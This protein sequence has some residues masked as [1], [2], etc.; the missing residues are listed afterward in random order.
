LKVLKA[1][2]FLIM[3]TIILFL[4]REFYYD[5][6]FD[7]TKLNINFSSLKEKWGNPDYEF[8]PNTKKDNRVFKYN[9]SIFGKYIFIADEKDSLIVRKAF[10][11]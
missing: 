6:K 11:D 2:A 8:V 5:K 9:K 3:I 1:I 7:S 10:D 4:G